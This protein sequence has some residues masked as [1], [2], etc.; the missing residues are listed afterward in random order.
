[1][2]SAIGE[3]V[4][5][6]EDTPIIRTVSDDQHEIIRNI[7]TLYVPEGF[8]LDP[9]YSKGVF[10]K[11][12]KKGKACS[13]TGIIDPPLKYDLFPKSD[14]VQKAS[15]EDLP[16]EDNS[17]SSIMFDP[18]FVAGHTK[19]APTGIIGKRFHGFRYVTDL[20]GWYD[21]C[22][23]EFNRILKKKGVLVFKCQDTVSSAKNWFSH[24]YIMERAIVHGFYPRDMFV[25]LA[26]HRITGHNH[27]KNQSHA[28][29]YHSYFWVFEKKACNV[30]YDID[31]INE[32]I[33]KTDERFE[34]RQEEE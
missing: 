32:I 26:K 25:L 7:Q 31:K 14:E 12:Y 17:I 19:T 23:A 34:K 10:Y 28:R 3:Q 8:E 2:P 5:V 29:K 20:W 21:Q 30:P 15:A 11:K 22:L 33:K 24:C 27:K 1:M 6:T 18:P 4:E 16:F 9:T 13:I